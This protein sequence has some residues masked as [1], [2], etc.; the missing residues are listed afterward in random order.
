VIQ[1]AV[2][3]PHPPVLIPDLA[4]GAAGELDDLRAACRAAIRRVAD[5]APQLVLMG[6]GP[7]WQRH[8]AVARGSL[9]PYGVPVEVALGSDAPGPV[10][11]PLSL[12]VGAW[13]VRDAM[14]AGSGAVGWSVGPDATDAPPRLDPADVPCAL[15]VMADGSA[16][17]STSAPGYLDER[18]TDHDTRLATGLR[19]GRPPLLREDATLAHD[20]LVEGGAVW[21]RASVELAG[22]AWDAELLFDAAPYGVGYFVAAWIA[23]D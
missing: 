7:R 3:C 6:A 14:G 1:A 23:R 9:A 22:R 5:V 17:R 18:A 13:L 8:E 12:T 19:E 10:E 2:F 20:L 4:Q 11:L 15:V 16:R 21:D